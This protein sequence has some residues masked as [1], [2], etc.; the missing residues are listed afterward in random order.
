MR[1]E[2]NPNPIQA[3]TIQWRPDARDVAAVSCLLLVTLCFAWPLVNGQQSFIA[4]DFYDQFHAFAAYEHDRLWSG[5]IP[6]WNPYTWGGHP[7]LADVQ[8]A[9]FY[10]PSLLTILL[11]GPGP[12]DPAWLQW[13][14]MAHLFLAALFTYLLMRRW[15]ISYARSH[16]AALIAALTFAFGGYLTGYPPLQLAIL[17]TQV[18]LPLILLLLDTGLLHF[19]RRWI[20]ATGVVWGLALL[21]GHP[22]SAMYVFYAAL[23]WGVFRSW[24]M[25]LPIWWAID[26][27]VWW[28]AIGAG[29]AAIHLLPAWEFMRL[30]VRAN[31][32]YEQLAGGF[33]WLDLAQYLLPGRFTL[34]S[35]V[36]VGL[37]PLGLALT[38]LVGAGRQWKKRPAMR[39]EVVFWAALALLTLILSLG[40]H[41]PLYRLFYHLVPGFNMFRSQER[42]IY[43]VSF[44]LAVLAGYGWLWL[45]QSRLCS[46][47]SRPVCHALC[48]AAVVLV[49]ADL[50][51]ANARTNLRPG[52]AAAQVYD[53]GWLQ[54]VWGDGLDRYVN[55]WGLPGNAGCL[56]RRQDMSGA[57]PLRLQAHRVMVEALPRW[58]LWQLFD[59]RYVVTWTHDVPEPLQG[60]LIAMQGAEWAQDTIYVHRLGDDFPRAW[61]VHQARQMTDL[62]V[63]STLADP[64][65]DPWSQVLLADAPPGGLT[66]AFPTAPSVVRQVSY[67]SERIVVTADL[68]AAGWLVLSEWDY[69]GWQAW[70][71]GARQRI[72]RADYALR[73]VPLL[74]GSHTVEFRYR[75]LSVYAG[76][77]LSAATL[78]GV[79]LIGF[80]DNRFR[81]KKRSVT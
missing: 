74:A 69:P 12:F 67:A 46:R 79:C 27:Q 6:L 43:L 33:G 41:T 30:S 52:P 55:E 65:F 50:W 9:V 72:Y 49:A 60:N 76:A 63:L 64:T 66:D 38:A 45:A 80:K 35:P 14:A 40:G 70:V 3:I 58:R 25:R 73:A 48:M 19:D 31:A 24:Q 28:A 23:I 62:Q 10:P 81:F 18:W 29:V 36:Y 71:D 2:Q 16:T 61:I 47:L 54:E 53:G 37:L 51:W 21:A 7:F 68:S 42:A 39:R 75:P 4:G 15:M 78:V 32:S 26:S 77:A 17:E 13:E 5:Q 59:V 8:A 56:L 34:W 22:Q 57:S 1:Y 20:T 44:S 11:S